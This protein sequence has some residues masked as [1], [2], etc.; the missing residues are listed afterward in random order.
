MRRRTRCPRL[1]RPIVAHIPT[2]LAATGEAPAA[3]ARD[4]PLMV[5]TA[6]ETTAPGTIRP[7]CR[8]L[9]PSLDLRVHIRTDPAEH[10]C[11]RS[12]NAVGCNHPPGFK[13]PILRFLSSAYT[14]RF[15][16]G[17]PLL[18]AFQAPCVTPAWPWPR[19]GRA[20]LS[21]ITRATARASVVPWLR[22]GSAP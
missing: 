5:P 20:S 19:S 1:W 7:T 11:H 9:P 6:P 15:F 10:D 13:S 14:R 21:F 12:A 16:A 3:A 18:S 2:T 4:G 17:R 8:S 22:A